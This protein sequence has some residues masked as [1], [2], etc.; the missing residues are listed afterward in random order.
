[1]SV[2]KPVEKI[3]TP[4][5]NDEWQARLKKRPQRSTKEIITELRQIIEAY[6]RKYRM[7]TNEFLP[8]YANGEFEM[9][10]SYPD[11]E[12]AHWQGSYE[13]YQR[14]SQTEQ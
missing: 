7:T 14:L 8:R 9:D 6:E 13:A 10:D 5:M 2:I 4:A 3:S 1:M 12:M 11:Y